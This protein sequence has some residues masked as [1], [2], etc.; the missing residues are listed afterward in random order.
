[1]PSEQEGWRIKWHLK[2]EIDGAHG[3]VSGV[4]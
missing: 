3:F 2:S 4:A 1:M